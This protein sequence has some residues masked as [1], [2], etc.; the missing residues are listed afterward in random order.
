MKNVFCLCIISIF[1][2]ASH[3]S[4]YHQKISFFWW[5]KIIILHFTRG[6]MRTF[7]WLTIHFSILQQNHSPFV[8]TLG[9]NMTL[10]PTLKAFNGTS[11]IGRGL[12]RRSTITSW[13]LPF[14]MLWRRTLLLWSA[15]I[16]PRWISIWNL[17]VG[18]F[19][20]QLLLH[21]HNPMYKF[22]HVVVAL[23]LYNIL[24]VPIQAI[25]KSSHC[26]LISLF[27]VCSYQR[28]LHLFVITINT[29]SF[30]IEPL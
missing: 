26:S 28:N 4:P 8:R 27:N 15:F 16:L 18:L 25:Q 10:S 3:E 21:F 5:K 29:F 9:C 20:L 7:R 1:A 14:K 24:N 17:I 2:Q 30:L 23:K 22:I 6:T 13:R 12:S 11:F 19:P